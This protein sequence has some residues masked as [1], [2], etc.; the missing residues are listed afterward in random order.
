MS[1][2]YIIQLAKAINTYTSVPDEEVKKFITVA[3][4]IEVKK[5]SI[6]SKRG[7]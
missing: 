7:I 1:E 5:M 4:P 3:P 2:S 6:S